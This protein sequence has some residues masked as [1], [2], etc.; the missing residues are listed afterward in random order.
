[1]ENADLKTRLNNDLRQAMRAGDTVKRDTIRFLLSDIKNTEIARNQPVDDA[2]VIG[3]ISKE[4]R[5]RTE[6]IDAFKAGNRPDLV[7]KEE[8]ELAVVKS[9]LP[10]QA[11]HEEIVTVA[12]RIIGEVGAKSPAERGKVIP[13]VIAELRGKAS[14]Q[15]ISSVVAELLSAKQ[16]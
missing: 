8:A 11:S 6:S 1:M 15:E 4:I 5:Q 7:A 16:G 3:V 13:K 14:G 9:Y 12:R 10:Q 2:G